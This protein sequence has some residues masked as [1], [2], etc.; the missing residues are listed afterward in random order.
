MFHEYFVYFWRNFNWCAFSLYKRGTTAPSIKNLI[1]I[2]KYFNCT[3]DYLFGRSPNKESFPGDFKES[4]I[5]RLDSLLVERRT[6]IY[7]VAK[8]LDFSKSIYYD[9]KKGSM[10]SVEKLVLLADYFGVSTDYLLGL[11][12]GLVQNDNSMSC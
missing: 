12:G 2:A 9:W 11:S 3:I 8:E 1:K 4:F 6:S 7:Y 5:N 10:P